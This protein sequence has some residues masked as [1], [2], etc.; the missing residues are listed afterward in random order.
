MRSVL[1]ILVLLMGVIAL[2]QP[3]R[4]AEPVRKVAIIVG[5][6]GE[7][8]T[9]TYI[10]IAEAAAARAE[11][12]GAVVARAY[13][14][15]ATPDRVLAA[16]EGANVVIYL[17]HGVGVPNPYSKTPDPSLVNGWGLQGP[18]AHGNHDDSWANGSLAY[19]GEAWIA[20]NAHPGPGLG[21]DLLQCLLC[22]RRKRRLRHARHA[23]DRRPTG[24]QL[25]AGSPHGARRIGLLRNRLLRGSCPAGRHHPGAAG[26]AVRADLRRRSPLRRGRGDAQSGCG[27]QDR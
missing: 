21:D 22:A 24:R 19:Y 9:P 23:R 5:P 3:A 15:D 4:G 27:R 18:K 13:S 8:L 16:V 10:A 12:A 26:A 6:V 11:A 1:S 25:L 20:A 2:P 17:G 14:P 7:K